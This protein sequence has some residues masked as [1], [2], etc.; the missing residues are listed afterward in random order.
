MNYG[1]EAARRTAG[2]GAARA[3]D[4]VRRELLTEFGADFFRAYVDSLRLLAERDGVVLFR[5]AS[6]IAQE[7]L[8]QQAQHRLEARLRAHMPGLVRVDILLDRDISDDLRALADV[9]AEGAS[10]AQAAAPVE[11]PQG[12]CFENFCVDQSNYRAFTVAQMIATGAGMAFPIWMLHS[13]PGCGKTHLINA[14]AGEAARLTPDRKVLLMSGQEFLESFQSALHKKRDSHAFKDMVRAPDLL[15]IDDFQGICGKKATEEE[16]FHTIRNLTERG[17]QV[18][19]TANHAANGLGG[20]HER[21]RDTLKAATSCEITE[22]DQALR[23][24]ILDM[25]MKH[26]AR[27]VA[28]FAV[29]PE[30]LDMIA[31]RMPVTGRELDGA[32]SQLVIEAKISGGQP[33]SLD[34]AV[35]ALQDKL[36]DVAHRRVTVQ[37]VQKVTARYYNM[38]VPQLLERTRR[39]AVA[40]PRQVAMFLATKL[41][42]A[43]LPYIGE[44]F[45]GFDHT[46]IMYARDKVQELMAKDAK[47]RADVEAIGKLA[48]REPQPT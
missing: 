45:G 48:R 38:T 36:A 24:Q 8:Q 2:V 16:A 19:I 17:R 15:L 46:T 14:I 40:R 18:V 3:Y 28:G 1:E 22:P 20:L 5:A 29:A 43:S 39:N 31:E 37:L 10:P 13:P 32:I 7:R 27:R 25:R 41:T 11:H 12:Y 42:R 6:Q 4:L 26:H 34:T 47:L 33:V 35:N 21:L 9:K 23:R 44:R 30:A